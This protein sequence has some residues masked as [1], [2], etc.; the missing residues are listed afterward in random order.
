QGAG[1]G[2]RLLEPALAYGESARGGIIL[3]TE[4]PRAIRLYALAGFEL[5][6]QMEAHGRVRRAAL[7][8]DGPVREGGPADLELA[9]AV[10][11]A[12]RGASH[13]PDLEALLAAGARMLVVP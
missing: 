2:A 12:V 3:S 5:H 11:R 8:A 6:P 13:G 4:D 9:A 10:G 7:S 1:I